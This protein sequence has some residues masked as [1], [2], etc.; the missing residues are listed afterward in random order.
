MH[1]NEDQGKRTRFTY[2]LEEAP[3]HSLNSLRLYSRA[4]A[5]ILK[6]GCDKELHVLTTVYFFKLTKLTSCF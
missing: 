1:I 3:Q 2:L 4:A 6:V 5:F